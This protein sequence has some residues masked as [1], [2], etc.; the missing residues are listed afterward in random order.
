M[1]NKT[2]R[3]YINLV[4]NAQRESVAEGK[5]DL[6][7]YSTDRLQAYVKKV[8]GG[9]VP[10]FGSGAQLKRVQAELKRRQQGVAE[11]NLNEGVMD[12]LKRIYMMLVNDM[13]MGTPESEFLAHWQR[14]IQNDLGKNIDI[15]TLA[16]L[17]DNFVNRYKTMGRRGDVGDW[18]REMGQDLGEDQLEETSPDAIEKIEQ[19]VRK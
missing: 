15:D 12:Q 5:D 9:G 4:E 18:H 2:L 6:S 7:Q 19:L 13:P 14:E 16:G 1:T 17:R 8:S 11:G 10:A 3:D